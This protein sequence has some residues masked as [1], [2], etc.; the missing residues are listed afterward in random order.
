MAR[1]PH[2]FTIPPGVNFLATFADQLIAGEIVGAIRTPLDPLALSSA[3][4]YVPT[5]RAARALREELI[6]RLAGPA[7]LLPK[8]VPLGSLEAIET[9][10]IFDMELDMPVE[11]V[12]DAMTPIER[13]LILMQLVHRWAMQLGTAITR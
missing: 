5:R 4:I 1:A 9:G 8:I 6:A 3:T 13:R 10:L 2:V 7:L 11:G 12:P